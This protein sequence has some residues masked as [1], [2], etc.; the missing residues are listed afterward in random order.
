M[1]LYDMDEAKISLWAKV[2]L[3]SVII[4]KEYFKEKCFYYFGILYNLFLYKI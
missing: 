3:L 4:A 2:T 1:Y